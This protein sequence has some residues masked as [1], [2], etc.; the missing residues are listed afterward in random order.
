MIVCDKCK[1]SEGHIKRAILVEINYEETNEHR[2]DRLDL[3]SECL[4]GFA[5][6]ASTF[7]QW[8]KENHCGG[9]TDSP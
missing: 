4:K 9:K 1:T 3:C 6:V 8:Y 7:I 5:L 2:E